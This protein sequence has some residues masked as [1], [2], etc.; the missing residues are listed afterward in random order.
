MNLKR[1]EG[2]RT[3]FTRAHSKYLRVVEGYLV[4]IHMWI[5]F[6]FQFSFQTQSDHNC[7]IFDVI[8]GCWKIIFSKLAMLR[9]LFGLLLSPLPPC[10]HFVIV[11]ISSRDAAEHSRE[12]VSIFFL[13]RSHIVTCSQSS[14]QESIS[15][16][17]GSTC[18][19]ME[20]NF[21]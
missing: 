12:H 9:F 2:R 18:G 1:I 14:N 13:L 5:H 15:N 21:H 3:F 19:S 4:G 7:L 6:K 16:I 10:T 8:I 17:I 11:H 20:G